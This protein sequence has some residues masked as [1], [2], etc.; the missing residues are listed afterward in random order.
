MEIRFDRVTLHEEVWSVPLTQLG[1][2][3]G[4]SD[5]GI[6][7]ICKAMNIPLPRAGHW[8]K[9]AAGKVVSKTPLPEECERDTYICHPPGIEIS[10][11]AVEDKKWMQGMVDYDRLP[12]NAISVD[13]KPGRWHPL[14]APFRKRLIE[15]AIKAEKDREVAERFAEREKA[16]KVRG[17]QM[18]EGAHDWRIFFSYGQ[19]L[20]RTHHS[21]PIRLSPLGYERAL[22]ILNTFLLQAEIRGFTVEYCEAKGRFMLKGHGAE[23]EIRISEKLEEAPPANDGS[24]KTFSWL[25]R[26]LVP[27]GRLRLHVGRSGYVEVEITD[28]GDSPLETKL[29]E[30]FRKVYL[31]VVRVRENDRK[32]QVWHREREEE[33]QRRAEQ[34][35]LRQEETRK[36]EEERQRAARLIR[37]ATDWQT[38]NL[39]RQYVAH[40]VRNMKASEPEE[41]L[42]DWKLWALHVADELDPTVNSPEQLGHVSGTPN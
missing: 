21:M 11:E 19:I 17:W 35:R 33:A 40:V 13:L 38:A 20:C 8:A 18:P 36:I 32:W 25:S 39:V 34:E 9:V 42:R 28:E 5:N 41:G 15:A 22:A 30:V 31:A 4:L 3:Y 24:E 6:R 27:T 23:I 16:G 29:G 7:K 26:I 12:E 14:V 10:Q 1:K 2:K 37:E